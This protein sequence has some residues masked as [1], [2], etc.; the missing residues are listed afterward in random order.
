MGKHDEISSNLGV[1]MGTPFL[2]KPRLTAGQQTHSSGC[3]CHLDTNQ[4][5]EDIDL[6]NLDMMITQRMKWGSGADSNLWPLLVKCGETI[7]LLYTFIYIYIYIYT[8]IYIYVFISYIYICI[9]NY[10]IRLTG[11]FGVYAMFGP[12]KQLVT[13]SVSLYPVAVDYSWSQCWQFTWTLVKIGAA[14]GT[15]HWDEL[16]ELDHDHLQ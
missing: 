3:L 7:E 6:Q 9:W 13:G 2:H 1:P 5:R 14:M 16:T 10:Y 12:T 8:C 15:L 4:T 11:G